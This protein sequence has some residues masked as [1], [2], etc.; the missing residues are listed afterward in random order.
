MLLFVRQLQAFRSF[1]SYREKFNL[2]FPPW[3]GF[4]AVLSPQEGKISHLKW[5]IETD[6]GVMIMMKQIE[7]IG[8][9]PSPA[10]FI[11]RLLLWKYNFSCCFNVGRRLTSLTLR[12]ERKLRMFR[13]GMLRRIFGPKRENVMGGWRKLC[14][15]K[16]HTL[17]SSPDIIRAVK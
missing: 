16:L 11:P 14:N 2:N 4:S 3:F 1:F 17:Y 6:R 9:D 7:M 13:N 15:E 5:P 8:Q 12:E 10:A